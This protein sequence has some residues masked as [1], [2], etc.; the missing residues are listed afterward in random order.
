[1]ELPADMLAAIPQLATF[2][3]EEVGE[4]VAH[5][6]LK[7]WDSPDVLPVF[8]GLVR[9]ATTDAVA[10]EMFRNVLAEGP[11]L[12]MARAADEPD[13]DLRALLVGSQLVGL[14][15]ARYIIKAEPLASTPPDVLARAIAP[16]I[17][18]YLKGDIGRGRPPGQPAGAAG[19][20]APVPD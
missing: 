12:A 13:A 14:A 15:M 4:R 1:M 2:A 11:L 3:P 18:R 16:T 19:A 20:P 5:V 6:I 8:L 9:S 7:L 17:Q 10:A